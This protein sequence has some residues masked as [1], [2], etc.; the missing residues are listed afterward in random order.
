MELYGTWSR[1]TACLVKGYKSSLRAINGTVKAKHE[2][3]EV[4]SRML[5]LN[6]TLERSKQPLHE[7]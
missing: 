7:Q 6:A 1:A 3:I 2:F 4:V 5:L